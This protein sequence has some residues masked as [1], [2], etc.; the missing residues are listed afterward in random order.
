[1]VTLDL[2]QTKQM[3]LEVAELAA[4]KMMQIMYP[5]QDE[6]CYADACEMVGDRRWVDF[7]VKAGNLKSHRRGRATNSKKFFSRMDIYALK[8]AE[9]MQPEL[10]YKSRVKPIKS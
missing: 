1:M 4:M 8:K 3:Y 5:A 7:H 10:S 2:F 6:V 9:T